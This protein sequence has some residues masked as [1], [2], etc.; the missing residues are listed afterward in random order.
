MVA[1]ALLFL[2]QLMGILGVT[3]FQK[4]FAANSSQSTPVVIFP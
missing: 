3:G 2:I 4:V 1:L